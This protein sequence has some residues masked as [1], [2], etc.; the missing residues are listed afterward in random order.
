MVLAKPEL[1]LL[2]LSG[3]I[4]KGASSCKTNGHGMRSGERKMA[5][6]IMNILR[7]HAML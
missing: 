7:G 6:L 1:G 5:K 2:V 3:R 4:F